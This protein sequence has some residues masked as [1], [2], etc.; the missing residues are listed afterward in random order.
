MTQCPNG[1]CAVDSSW[2]FTGGPRSWF[3]LQVSP[4]AQ[5][6]AGTQIQSAS[7]Q[8]CVDLPGGDT[9]NGALLQMWE[10]IDGSDTQQWTFQNNMLVYALDPTKCVDLLGGD[11]TNGNLLGLWDC[12]NSES[13]QWGFDWEENRRILSNFSHFTRVWN[14]T[15]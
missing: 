12:W 5:P 6:V 14:F 11:A 4:T 1:I 8:K 15:I 3:Y 9:T 2:R 7:Y 13:Q 10:C